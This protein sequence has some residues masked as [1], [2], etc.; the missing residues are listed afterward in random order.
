MIGVCLFVNFRG[1]LGLL[2]KR[3]GFCRLEK[4]GL[5]TRGVLTVAVARSVPLVFLVFSL[6]VWMFPF[7]LYLLLDSYPTCTTDVS[8]CR[9]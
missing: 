8:S 2:R 9:D 1:D 7:R 3:S 5:L 6:C 4:T